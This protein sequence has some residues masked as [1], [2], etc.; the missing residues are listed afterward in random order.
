[1]T[2]VTALSGC[3]VGD[4]SESLLFPT[5]EPDIVTPEITDL[6]GLKEQTIGAKH[7]IVT[8]TEGWLYRDSE[9]VISGDNVEI[10]N[11]MFINCQVF[12]NGRSNV[13]FHGCIFTDLYQYEKA[14]LNVNESANISVIRCGFSNN[15]IG[16]GVHSGRA[17]IRESR[18]ESNNGH[19]ALVIGEGSTV[20][21]E[22]NYFYGNFPHAILIMNRE[23]TPHT[24]VDILGNIIEQTGEDAIDFEDYR[25][26]SESLVAGNIIRNT[27]WSAIIVEYNSWDS[28]ITISG[29]WIEG[30]R[31]TWEL[32]VHPLQPEEFQLGWGHGVLVEDSSEVT[33][34]NNRILAAGE[35]GIE[36]RNSRE[37][38]V[39]GNGISCVLAGIGAYGYNNMSL[40]REFSP[41]LP[42][43]A[44]GTRA[45]AIGNIIFEAGTEY[46]IDERSELVLD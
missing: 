27:G 20:V 10:S 42:E 30:T 1:M 19:N 44:G 11:T 28:N 41:L 16:M 4:T 45:T 38:L 9:V 14:A 34:E 37:V 46:E 24:K 2:L 40:S 23:E 39:K 22:G 26:A 33:I 29:N 36:I 32:P 18:F 12:V 43:N 17:E 31:I 13:K 35:N 7:I 21:V 6:S 8:D 3:R 5:V 15:Y 25:H